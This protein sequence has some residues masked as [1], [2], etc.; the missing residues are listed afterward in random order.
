MGWSTDLRMMTEDIQGLGF[1]V[2]KMKVLRDEG[3]RTIFDGFT[4]IKTRTGLKVTMEDFIKDKLPKPTW[5]RPVHLPM[6]PF[7]T[8]EDLNS[9]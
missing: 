4:L 5:T 6:S 9:A 3:D 8:D 7:N 1:K 2:G